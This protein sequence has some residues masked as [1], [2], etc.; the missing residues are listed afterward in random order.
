MIVIKTAN[1]DIF[2]NE[3]EIVSL[4]HNRDTHTVDLVKKNSGPLLVLRPEPITNV[5]TVIYLNDKQPAQWCDEGSAVRY[6][7]K[8]VDSYR[9]ELACRNEIIKTLKDKLLHL[10]HECVQYIQYSK[11]ETP[12][13]RKYLRDIGEDAKAYVNHGEDEIFKREYMQSHKHPEELEAD[14]IAR[15]NAQIEDMEKKLREQEAQIH[16]ITIKA[17]SSDKWAG[18]YRQAH[19]RLMKRNLWKRIINEKTYL[20]P[21]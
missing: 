20:W 17:E 19:E 12:D 5:E 16:E 21:E 10:G 7:Q 14:E 8:S 6:L 15:L 2:V 11:F 13:G 1:G 18:A 9:T 3:S 4:H